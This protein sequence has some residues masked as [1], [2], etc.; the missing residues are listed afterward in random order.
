MKDFIEGQDCEHPVVVVGKQGQQ[1]SAK[2]V[3]TCAGLYSDKVAKMTDCK[4]SPKIIPVRGEYLKMVDHKQ[5]IVYRNIYP[6]PDPAFP[7]LGVHFNPRIDGSMWLGPN[8]VLA[9]KKE[10]YT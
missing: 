6:V 8:A 2:C 1:L 5:N 7:F 3:L 10:G 9:F 4:P